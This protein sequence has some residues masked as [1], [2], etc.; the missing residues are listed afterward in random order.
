MCGMINKGIDDRYDVVFGADLTYEYEDLPLLLKAI[1]IVTDPQAVC[2]IAYG[3]VCDSLFSFVWHFFIAIERAVVGEFIRMVKERYE[4]VEVCG[5]LSLSFSLSF[6]FSFSL[7][8]FLT[9]SLSHFLTFS[10]SH[11]LTF[12]LSHFLTYFW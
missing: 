9:F 5:F 7:S 2:M 3:I 1:E 6:S 10:L 11:F 8:L 12:S 4:S